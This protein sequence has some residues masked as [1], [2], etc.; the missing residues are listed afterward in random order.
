MFITSPKLP[1]IPG[2]SNC[3]MKF[4]TQ[5][6]TTLLTFC[7]QANWTNLSRYSFYNE[8]TF[9]RH[10]LNKINFALFNAL[11]LSL[12][13]PLLI[14]IDATTIAKAG[15]L[16]YGVGKFWSSCV[17]QVIKGIEYSC[18]ALIDPQ[19]PGAY[20]FS[21][22]QTPSELSDELNRVDFYIQQLKELM[23]FFPKC[24]KYVVADGF[25]A[26][27]KFGQAVIEMGLNFITK[28]RKDAQIFQL[29]QPRTGKRGRPQKKGKRVK[30]ADFANTILLKEGIILKWQ[31]AYVSTFERIC[32]VV[33]IWK[34][35]EMGCIFCSTD[36]TLDPEKVVEYYQAR[37][38]HEILFRDAKQHTG[39]GDCQSRDK[40]SLDFHAN[41]TLTA[42]NIARLE[43][44]QNTPFSL[45]TIKRKK[46]N[47][48]I[49]QN[50]FNHLNISSEITKNQQ[51]I[52][53][54]EQIANFAC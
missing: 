20:H 40:E 4:L 33:S 36:T 12:R 44:P 9:R 1:K 13:N 10:A 3:Q 21:A 49:A 31:L 28:L 35:G 48:F 5:L 30:P 6:F 24:A 17:G 2:M 32:L 25:Y 41:A 34:D 11:L 14:A 43:A 52:Q 8:R 45:A 38:Q 37:F 39:F 26:K 22:S 47:L 50:I 29:P 46:L 51:F 42:V 53:I 27:L 19:N 54:I 7:G 16:T 18:V 15:K 23:P